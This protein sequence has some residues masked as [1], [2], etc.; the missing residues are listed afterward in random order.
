MGRRENEEGSKNDRYNY[1]YWYMYQFS[2]INIILLHYR[3]ANICHQKLEK[4][5]NFTEPW[6]LP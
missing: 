2:N 6:N 1:S 3:Y 4:D 5:N